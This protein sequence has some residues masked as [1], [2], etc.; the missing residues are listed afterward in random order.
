MQQCQEHW[1]F[2][3]NPCFQDEGEKETMVTSHLWLSSLEFYAFLIPSQLALGWRWYFFAFGGFDSAH[4]S[5]LIFFLWKFTMTYWFETW[6]IVSF[7][8]LPL[9]WCYLRF[10]KQNKKETKNNFHLN[11]SQDFHLSLSGAIVRATKTNSMFLTFCWSK[12][13]LYFSF[14]FV[15]VC[16]ESLFSKEN[17]L[18]YRHFIFN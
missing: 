1:R 4:S 16:A 11:W 3:N 9:N 8:N 15:V 10:T 14:R 13:A 17:M 18:F 2:H 12:L 7:S 5:P 6:T